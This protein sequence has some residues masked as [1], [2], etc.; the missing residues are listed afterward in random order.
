MPTASSIDHSN[1][2]PLLITGVGQV[3]A[4]GQSAWETFRSLLAGRTI[5]DRLAELPEGVEFTNQVRALGGVK[6]AQHTATDPAVDLAERAAREALHDAGYSDQPFDGPCFVGTSKG[7]VTAWSAAAE[8]IAQGQ[9]AGKGGPA[10][11]HH[12]NLHPADAALATILGPHGYLSHHLGQRLGVP[13]TRN[14]VAACA[15]SLIALDAAR[16]HLLA[17]PKAKRAL[18]VTSESALL[19][20][21]V[22]AYRRLGVL[23]PADQYIARPFAKQQ[24]GFTLGE[25]AAAVV[26]E[27]ADMLPASH[28]AH[29]E[30][31]STASYNDPHDLIRTN[32]QGQAMQHVAKQVLGKSGCDAL[33]AH[34]P[35]TS[36]H[37]RIELDAV[38]QVQGSL[39]PV[40]ALKGAIGHG[41]GAS[42][43]MSL[44]TA[45]L[46]GKA[47]RLPPMPW[48]PATPG[49]TP[50][51][52][53]RTRSASGSSEEQTQ[54][55]QS[56]SPSGLS[57]SASPRI[58]VFAAGFAGHT[59]GAMIQ[60][61]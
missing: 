49:S 59:A 41:L 5:S 46:C 57:L 34:A 51:N 37:E 10:G 4:L 42:G 47:K 13:V 9:A 58:A 3:S 28:K 19:P 17:T 33:L 36:I 53:S 54:T 27:R 45:C 1:A 7:C 44:V 26:L 14:I 23:C 50:E 31:V 6:T 21:F 15:S 24:H 60:C 12:D 52:T 55:I 11:L 29:A 40:Y 48:L 43:L 25:Q 8:A 22:Y 38:T 16:R 39:P 56:A 2:A 32:P 18:V 20:L 61:Q 30:L 35:G